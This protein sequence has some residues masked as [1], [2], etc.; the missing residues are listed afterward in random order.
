MP[1]YSNK[2]LRKD[3]LITLAY[4]PYSPFRVKAILNALRP[5]GYEDLSETGLMGQV[6]YLEE[7]GYVKSEMS[8]NIVT[9]EEMLLVTITSKGIDLLEGNCTD[10]GIDCAR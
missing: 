7:K 5:T 8:R 1:K 4:V 3:I 6:K 10:V 2:T 9:E